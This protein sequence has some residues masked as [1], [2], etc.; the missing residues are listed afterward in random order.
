MNAIC[1]VVDRLHAG[2][3]GCYG[4]AWISTP[5]LSRLAAESF[6]LD[7]AVVDT[8][9]LSGLYRSW[10]SG[11]HAAEPD[12]AWSLPRALSAAGVSTTLISDTPL[13]DVAGLGDIADRIDVQLAQPSHPVESIEETQLASFF[14]AAVEWLSTPR[15]PFMLWLH[16]SSLGT[17]WD[18]PVEFRNQYADEDE[19]APPEMVDVPRSVLPKDYDPD[20][21]LGI[22]QS[23]AGQ[24]SLFDHCLGGFMEFLETSPLAANTLLVVLSARGLALGEHRRIGAWDDAL[25]AELVDVPWLMRFPDRLGA[26]ARSQAVVQPPDLCAT[27]LDWWGVP[28]E[29]SLPTAHP[30]ARSLLPLVR[31]EV[32]TI[33]DRACSAVPNGERAIRTRAWQLRMPGASPMAGDPVPPTPRLYAKPDDR[34]EVNDV[35]IRCPEIVDSLQQA[36]AD[37]ERL[38]AAGRL[39]ELMPLDAEL[40]S[41]QR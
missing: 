4:N 12:A 29:T 13:A 31:D 23:Y 26:S 21:L 28:A 15:E 37:F 11:R 19:P 32:Q 34:W 10:W 36:A 2:Y 7:Q 1:L 6:V 22:A 17:T 9:T 40:V 14:A 18:A 5:A 20:E 33:R 24:V 25:H 16:A 3:V 8:P 27:L 35:A 30:F 39:S 41:D 38:A